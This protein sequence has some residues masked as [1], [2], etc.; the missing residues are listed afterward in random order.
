MKLSNLFYKQEKINPMKNL[1][2]ENVKLRQ[3]LDLM[4]A[5]FSHQA[6]ETNELYAIRLAEK[7]LKESLS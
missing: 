4:L 6:I 2:A 7:V 1:F 3:A 5:E